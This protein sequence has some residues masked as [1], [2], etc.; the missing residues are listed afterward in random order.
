MPSL[1]KSHDQLQRRCL[2]KEN[3]TIKVPSQKKLNIK[4]NMPHNSRVVGKSILE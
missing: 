2:E 4:D 1:D 3:I